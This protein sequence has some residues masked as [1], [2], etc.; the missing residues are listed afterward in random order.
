MNRCSLFIVLVAAILLPLHV[1]G[2]E[3]GYKSEYPPTYQ[4]SAGYNFIDLKGAKRVLEY[5]EP[6]DS[7]TF[8]GIAETYP[9]PHRFHLEVFSLSDDNYYLDTGYAYRDILLSRLVSI[10]MVHNHRHYDFSFPSASPEF[11]YDERNKGDEY[12]VKTSKTEFTLRLKVPNYP[13][14][15]FTRYFNYHKEGTEQ[16]RFAIGYFEDLTKTSQSRDIDFDTK[17]LTM[18]TNGHFGPLEIE[19]THREKNFL[20]GGDDTLKDTYPATTLRPAD[21]FPHNVIPELRSS[22]DFIKIHTSYTGR[23]VGSLTLGNSRALN[24]FSGAKREGFYSGIQLSYLPM[25]DLGFFIRWHYVAHDNNVDDTATLRG[26]NYAL[27][28]SL[29]QPIDR[30]THSISF[31]IRYR[32]SKAISILGG[33][34][35]TSIERSDADAWPRL[36]QN[37]TKQSF[38]LKVYGRLLKR[39]KF[40]TE[41][42]FTNTRNPVYNSAPEKSHVIRLNTTYAPTAWLTGTVV[43]YF[44]KYSN[45]NLQYYEYYA[46][47]RLERG[48]RDGTVH[49]LLA[50]LTFIP[51]EKTTISIGTG[52]YRNRI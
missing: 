20:P 12:E 32:P 24:H 29:R 28:Y 3:L 37:T 50:L 31:N 36:D 9:L 15:V 2:L 17:E 34:T 22:S 40:R 52:F 13:F 21:T 11:H 35:L 45:D 44:K 5:S 6:D 46:D 33:Y 51:Q 19:Y 16:Q 8:K 26:D 43:Y 23:I 41:Y 27:T 30:K 10:G 7:I 42:I 4:L 38:S 14:H 1:Y 39:L 25:H 48:E 18:G 49:N 47:E